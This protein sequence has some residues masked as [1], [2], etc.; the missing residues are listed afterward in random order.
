MEVFPRGRTF[1]VLLLL[2]GL[3]RLVLRRLCLRR[4]RHLAL[5][6]GDGRRLGLVGE[7][8][9][10]DHEAD[11]EEDE[12]LDRGDPRRDHRGDAPGLNGLVLDGMVHGAD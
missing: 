10:A 3:R 4:L 12:E 7:G 5:D 11:E 2:G 9:R 8:L 1:G 6:G